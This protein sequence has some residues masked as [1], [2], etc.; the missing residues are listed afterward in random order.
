MP[1]NDDIFFLSSVSIYIAIFQHQNGQH[2]EGKFSLS[3][4]A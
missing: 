4:K 2:G 1:V 3:D